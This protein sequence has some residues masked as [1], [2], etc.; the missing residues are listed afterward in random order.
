MAVRRGRFIYSAAWE[1]DPTGQ[2]DLDDYSD[3]SRTKG[4]DGRPISSV[5]GTFKTQAV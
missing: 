4:G 2:L 3:H 1:L 5:F